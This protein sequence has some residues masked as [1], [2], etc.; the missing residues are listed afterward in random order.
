MLVA[1][2]IPF[3]NFCVCAK[4]QGGGKERISPEARETRTFA[5][6][7]THHH[8]PKRKKLSRPNADFF[9]AEL[10]TI[11]CCLQE[12]YVL[13]VLPKKAND[14]C[15]TAKT[16]MPAVCS[17]NVEVGFIFALSTVYLQTKPFGCM[18]PLGGWGQVF[19]TAH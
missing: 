18:M 13:L 17:A 11:V 19:A 10:L 1:C 7:K 4:G 9:L 16:I 6:A 2:E 5:N 12:N 15:H 14:C 8:L 3:C